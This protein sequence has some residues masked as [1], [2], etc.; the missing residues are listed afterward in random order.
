MRRVSR[1]YR[2][3]RRSSRVYKRRSRFFK[4]G[5]R[6]RRSYRTRRFGTSTKVF[7]ARRTFKRHLCESHTTTGKFEDDAH[8]KISNEPLWF[9]SFVGQHF[10]DGSFLQYWYNSLT[11]LPTNQTLQSAPGVELVAR[12]GYRQASECRATGVAVR[13][14]MVINPYTDW[15]VRV[16]V[17]RAENS[18]PNFPE[19]ERPRRPPKMDRTI[20]VDKLTGLRVCSNTVDT[21]TVDTKPPFHPWS[22]EKH[23]PFSTQQSHYM[24][25]L[26]AMQ[27]IHALFD[28]TFKVSNRSNRIR[29]FTFN[30]L[31]K[32]RH[33]LQY[34]RFISESVMVEGPSRIE[35][36]KP[37]YIFVI[38]HPTHLDGV[39]PS[40]W[41][42]NTALLEQAD[43]EE[44]DDEMDEEEDDDT[45][46]K[47][48][49]HKRTVSGDFSLKASDK[50]KA[51]A[52]PEGEAGPSRR[53]RF[54]TPLENERGEPMR[55]V[56]IEER[57]SKPAYWTGQYVPGWLASAHTRS[58]KT[59]QIND[60]TGL[61]RDIIDVAEPVSTEDD[62]ELPAETT[63][64][65]VVPVPFRALARPEDQPLFWQGFS[66][67]LNTRLWFTNLYRSN[68]RTVN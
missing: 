6:Y 14:N 58:V 10:T 53:P 64:R 49:R 32:L 28:G 27:G 1:G 19:H 17:V 54:M 31:I 57:I 40:R 59:V 12:H 13:A 33:T 60:T 34:Q 24:K 23:D 46:R 63:S 56:D 66:M 15:S 9:K 47:R 37:L 52:P 62:H 20:H 30:R 50:G 43:E 45:S 36:M 4:K 41:I 7:R 35:A 26:P 5:I 48:K 55:E 8:T 39:Y 67:H 44:A 2:K 51:R 25:A 21:L 38:A 22:K 61:L 16:L 65:H 68:A 29:T 42:S 18:I 3:T 11:M